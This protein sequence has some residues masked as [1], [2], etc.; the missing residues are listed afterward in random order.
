MFIVAVAADG[1]GKLVQSSESKKERETMRSSY[2][3][4]L[5]LP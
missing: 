1:G 2:A 4:L 3:C 5:A